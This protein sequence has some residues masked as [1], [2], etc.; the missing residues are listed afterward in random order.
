MFFARLVYFFSINFVLFFRFFLI[1]PLLYHKQ[2]FLFIFYNTVCNQFVSCVR[3]EIGTHHKTSRMSERIEWVDA[4][5]I[6]ECA[7]SVKLSIAFWDLSIKWTTCFEAFTHN[8]FELLT[9]T[10]LVGRYRGVMCIYLCNFFF[11]NFCKVSLHY[12]SCK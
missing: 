10:F 11:L 4:P 2:E 1:F 12:R 7:S 9:A 5:Y 3:H 8:T 6:D